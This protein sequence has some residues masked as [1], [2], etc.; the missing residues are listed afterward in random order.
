MYRTD[1][2]KRII[3]SLYYVKKRLAWFD[4]FVT[5][6]VFTKHSFSDLSFIPPSSF[7]FARDV[8]LIGVARLLDL[9]ES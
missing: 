3:L 6:A 9:H 7:L 5:S 8:K 4:Q 2:T 1:R